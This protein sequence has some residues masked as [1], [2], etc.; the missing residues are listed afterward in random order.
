MKKKIFYSIAVSGVALTLLS[1]F[2]MSVIS[3]LGFFA[4][5]WMYF[6]AYALVVFSIVG[7]IASSFVGNLLGARLDTVKKLIKQIGQGNLDIEVRNYQ[8]GTLV[9]D[10]SDMAKTLSDKIE[11]VTVTTD[12]LSLSSQEF[13]S[14]SAALANISSEQTN[15][16]DVLTDLLE[17]V[18]NI[19]E[20]AAND[21]KK[22]QE[23]LKESA[24]SMLTIAEKISVISDIAAQTNL[25]ALNA[26]VE[27]ARAGEHG[28]GFAVVASEVRKL[29][30]R[31]ELAAK[32]INEVSSENVRLAKNS[33]EMF[34]SLA[35]AILESA[36]LTNQLMTGKG[37][38]IS[39]VNFSE[40]IT[41]NAA[42]SE[43]LA[44]SSEELTNQV[45]KLKELVQG[46]VVMK[47]ESL[48][49]DL[50]IDDNQSFTSETFSSN[51][52]LSVSDETVDFDMG[53][54]NGSG[55]FDLGETSDFSNF[56]S[57]IDR[58]KGAS[59]STSGDDEFE[60]F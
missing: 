2:L 9:N 57:I 27:A 25:L 26:S 22:G 33:L 6:F 7:W 40:S 51:I 46:F 37:I 48:D 30:T 59:S 1:G 36:E 16:G 34:E 31:S 45:E 43:E 42:S 50:T 32:E 35:P 29:A 4:D 15:F 10:L 28:K 24:D 55:D 8:E 5:Y 39:M 38:D 49:L 56:Q 44:S 58:Q 3:G 17:N 19:S 11:T 20:K 52:D 13:K 14:T 41:Q 18:R 53:D 21:V 12:Y 47:E 54:S 60:D 23:I